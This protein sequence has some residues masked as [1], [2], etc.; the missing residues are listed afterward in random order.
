MVRDNFFRMSMQKPL[1]HSLV[2]GSMPRSLTSSANPLPRP[3]GGPMPA[4]GGSF[5]FWFWFCSVRQ[6]RA[7]GGLTQCVWR[8]VRYAKPPYEDRR[9]RNADRMLTPTAC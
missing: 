4:A 2:Y 3:G 9:R 7:A 1:Q 6:N 8:C 5:L